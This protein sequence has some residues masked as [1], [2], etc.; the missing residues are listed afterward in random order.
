MAMGIIA[1]DKK[2]ITWIGLPGLERDDASLLAVVA[3]TT[4]PSLFSHN[5]FDMFKY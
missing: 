4:T 5:Y 3:T 1:K 2:E